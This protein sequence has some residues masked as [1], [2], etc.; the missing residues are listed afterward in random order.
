MTL[1]LYNQFRTRLISNH[2]GKIL[3]SI[4]TFITFNFYSLEEATNFVRSL[5]FDAFIA[6][7]GGSVMDTAKAANLFSCDPQAPLLKYVNA[8][9]GE[10]QPVTVPLKPLY[11]GKIRLF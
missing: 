3:N 1:G 6:V 2:F 9:I 4:R 8:P 11:A 5:Q 7:G 10:G